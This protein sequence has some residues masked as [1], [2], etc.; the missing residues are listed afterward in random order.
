MEAPA[1]LAEWGSG[2]SA[3]VLRLFIPLYALNLPHKGSLS[4]FSRVGE[5]QDRARTLLREALAVRPK[6]LRLVATACPP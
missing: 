1:G 3:N 4:F 5:P 6:V 2:V